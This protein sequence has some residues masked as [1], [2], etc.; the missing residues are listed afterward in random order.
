[1]THERRLAQAIILL[2]ANGYTVGPPPDTRAPASHLPSV[3]QA[4]LV[5]PI[6]KSPPIAEGAPPVKGE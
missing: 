6:G 4:A 5:R 1:M 2:R 3:V